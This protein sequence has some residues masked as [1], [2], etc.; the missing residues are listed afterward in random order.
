MKKNKRNRVMRRFQTVRRQPAPR[1]QPMLR[2]FPNCENMEFGGF[3]NAFDKN[4][5]L[6]YTIKNVKH[7]VSKYDVEPAQSLK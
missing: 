3:F 6:Y 1:S 2:C 7:P 4:R 5:F